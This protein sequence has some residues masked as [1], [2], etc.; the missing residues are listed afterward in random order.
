MDAGCCGKQDGKLV[1]YSQCFYVEKPL[2][3]QLFV[4]LSKFKLGLR[5]EVARWHNTAVVHHFCLVPR[6]ECE[7][8]NLRLSS[9]KQLCCEFAKVT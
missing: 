5:R 7:S 3:R 9:C 1:Q 6:T 8:R 2:D 4:Q